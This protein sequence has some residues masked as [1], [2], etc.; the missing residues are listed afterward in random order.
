MDILNG[1]PEF[2]VVIGPVH[3]GKAA[4]D[5]RGDAARH[6]GGFDRDGPGAAEGIQQR[7][8]R[9]PAGGHQESGGQGLAQRGLGHG[10]AVAAFVQQHPGRVHA[11]GALVFRQPDDDQLRRVAQT[12]RPL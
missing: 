12:P 4:V 11:D 6:Q 9:V 7:R 5:A 1:K 3:E 2:L 10:L 8:G